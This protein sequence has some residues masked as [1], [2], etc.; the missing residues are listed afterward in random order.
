MKKAMV[1]CGGG[2]YGSLLLGGIDQLNTDNIRMIAGTS[3]GAIIGA[4]LCV[5]YNTQEILERLVE[6]VPFVCEVDIRLLFTDYG[7]YD[8]KTYLE[9]IRVML[10]KK[11]GRDITFQALYEQFGRDLVITGTNVTQGSACYFNR[12]DNPDMSVMDALSIST[13][14]PFVFPCARYSNEVY[15]DGAFMDNLPCVYTE[16]YLAKHYPS[17]SFQ[18]TVLNIQYKFNDL[19]IDSFL[20]FVIHLIVMFVN[21]HTHTVES[22]SKRLV[23]NLVARE[24]VPITTNDKSML[25]RLF[26]SGQQQIATQLK[27][28]ET[29][30]ETRSQGS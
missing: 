17:E 9:P 27:E 22:T 16:S 25:R 23:Y 29:Q 28:C 26:E 18:T 8:P 2:V 15:V 10:F 6:N 12:F 13:R 1:I 11:T 5:G 19:C 24:L 7:L 20:N 21:H 3:A 30:E 4:L 14:V